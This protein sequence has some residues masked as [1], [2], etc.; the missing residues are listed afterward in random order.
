MSKVISID[1]VPFTSDYR[2]DCGWCV[3]VKFTIEDD[4]Y[5]G[6][7]LYLIKKD[8]LNVVTTN[9]YYVF[10]QCVTE[11]PTTLGALQELEDIKNGIISDKYISPV[12]RYI[13]H[14]LQTLQLYWD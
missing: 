5:N 3:T 4:L 14:A 8:E 11:T 12:E 7:L 9:E 10:T 13:I 2:K 6:R 1:K